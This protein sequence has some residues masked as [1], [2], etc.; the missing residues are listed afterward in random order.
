[1][2][3][4]LPQYAHLPSQGQSPTIPRMITY[5][6]ILKMANH[7][8]QEGHPSSPRWSPSICGMVN[9]HPHD[10]HPLY[11]GWSATIPRSVIHHPEDSHQKSTGWVPPSSERSPSIPRTSQPI[12][13]WW[14][15]TIQRMVTHQQQ[16]GHPPSWGWSPTILRMVTTVPRTVSHLIQDGQPDMEFD[17]R[18]GQL[19]YIRI[20]SCRMYY[21]LIENNFRL[22]YSNSCSQLSI[23]ENVLC[24][25][26]NK[27]LGWSL[28]Q[29][30]E[31]FLP[32]I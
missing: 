3:T 16:D 27:F 20:F 8:S 19:V 31:F 24:R 17:S 13:I 18:A 7:H 4:N 1:M 32:C 22:F 26:V 30:K 11:P 10:G 6:I 23:T 14:S 29:L 12:Y 21:L 15:P 28:F 2:V 25:T 5:H 9:H